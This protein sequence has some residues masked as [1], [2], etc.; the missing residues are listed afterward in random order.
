MAELVQALLGLENAH[1]L[2]AVGALLRGVAAPLGYDRV[3]VFATGTGLER[4]AQR[5]YWIEGDWFGDG[6]DTDL[7][8]YL[9]T[10]PVNR[11]VLDSDAPFFWSKRQGMRGE[12]YQVV[13]QPRGEGLHGLQVPVFGTTGLEGAISF[14]G[15][16]IDAS[17]RARLLLEAVATAAFRTARRLAEAPAELPAGALSTREREVLRWVAAGRRQAE[18]AATLGLSARTVE[19]HLRRARQRLGVATTAQAVR[20]ASRRGEIED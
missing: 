15:T 4:D 3:L 11:H 1:S 13:K 18:I 6:S 10:C 16:A 2:A 19:N 14:A 12:R 7:A 17:A 20:A 8:R 9:H 5:V